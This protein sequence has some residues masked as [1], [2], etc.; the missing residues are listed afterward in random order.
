MGTSLD[1]IRPAVVA[2][3]SGLAA[4]YIEAF[5][6]KFEAL[7]GRDRLAA[8]RNALTAM[9]QATGQPGLEGIFVAEVQE[10]EGKDIAGAIVLKTIESPSAVNWPAARAFLLHLGLWASLRGLVGLLLLT[11]RP[12]AD[13]CY[14]DTLGVRPP[15]QGH[16]LGSA[17]LVRAERYARERGKHWLTLDVSSDNDEARRLYQRHGFETVELRHNWLATW[18][19]GLPPWYFM[20]KPVAR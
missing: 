2:D 13:E 1:D 15:W 10:P 6:D 9:I 12:N 3:A 18:L 4:V 20:R 7:F 5:E 14:I 17:L 16:G 19:L 8:T 11:E